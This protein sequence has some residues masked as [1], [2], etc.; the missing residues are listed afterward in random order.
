MGFSGALLSALVQVRVGHDD[1]IPA[2]N[3]YKFSV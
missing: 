3:S 2:C 1:H